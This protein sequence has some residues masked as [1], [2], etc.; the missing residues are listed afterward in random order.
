MIALD[1]EKVVY[2]LVDSR[3]APG[4]L[5]RPEARGDRRPP[6]VGR[7]RC[8]IA[9]QVAWSDYGCREAGGR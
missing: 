8:G 4:G 9:P 6:A 5:R 3:G 1:L 2:V 7:E